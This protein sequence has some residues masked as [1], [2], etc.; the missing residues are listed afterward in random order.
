MRFLTT[1][2]RV[3][4]RALAATLVRLAQGGALFVRER[5]GR[6][7]IARL[8]APTGH[9]PHEAAFLDC[10]FGST[11]ELTLGTGHARRQLRRAAA[12]LGI[13]LRAER[14]GFIIRNTRHFW[15]GAAISASGVAL[16][17]LMVDDAFGLDEGGAYAAFV[18][19]VAIAVNWTFWG[20]LK[21]P[22]EAA[23]KLLD[24]I[25]GFRRF[26]EAAHRDEVSPNLPYAM[27]FGIDAER[28]SILGSLPDW[29]AGQSG[30]FSA[31]D[32]TAALFRKAPRASRA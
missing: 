16:A 13:A 22:T 25:E 2:H 27:A 24:E 30:G 4:A 5:E 21:A 23:R 6:Y 11:R 28:A 26:L 29:Y 1:G 3:D 10:L 20:L 31:A 12:T 19:T 8:D 32:F 9:A 17:L 15:P 7:R 14:D 18:V